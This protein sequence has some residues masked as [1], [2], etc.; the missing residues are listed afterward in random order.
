MADTAL[1]T[2]TGIIAIVRGDYAAHIGELS[3]AL[4]AGGVRVMEVTLNSPGALDMIAA[5]AAQWTGRMLI[6]AGTVLTVAQVDAAAT[7]G[8]AFCVSPDTFAPVV[9]RAAGLGLEPIPGA[10]TPSE[11]RTA[12]RAGARFVKLFPAM[13]AG[14]AYLSQLRAPLD[15]VL[16]VPTGGVDEGNLAAFVRAGAVAA[17][18]G[19][20]LVPKRLDSGDAQLAQIEA[21]ARRLT[22]LFAGSRA[23]HD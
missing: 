19:S 1:I 11:I 15:D 2:S 12:A 14:P 23:A 6:G 16:F 18:V 13:P 20:S 22:G 8:A 3:A 5:L 10:F 7:A 9:E 17:G 21:A 4:Y